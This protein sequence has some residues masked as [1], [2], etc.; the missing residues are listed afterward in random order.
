MDHVREKVLPCKII[1]I[2]LVGH[3]EN[4][5]RRNVL[6]PAKELGHYSTARPSLLQE[7][8]GKGG[9]GAIWDNALQY[10]GH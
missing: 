7:G 2:T 4:F 6:V 5:P 9:R 3:T 10:A 1:S 8:K